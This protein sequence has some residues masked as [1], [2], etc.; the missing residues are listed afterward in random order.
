MIKG[1]LTQPYDDLGARGRFIDARSCVFVHFHVYLRSVISSSGHRPT[2]RSCPSQG[3]RGSI[4][5]LRNFIPVA[6]QVSIQRGL[7]RS[8]CNKSTGASRGLPVLVALR[9]RK[10][11]RLHRQ[12]PGL[13]WKQLFPASP[14]KRIVLLAIGW[15]C[16]CGDRPRSPACPGA[17]VRVGY[18]VLPAFEWPVPGSWSRALG[19]P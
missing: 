7:P 11:V 17:C 16:R 18:R 13:K 6:G 1:H 9:L 19:W 4:P 2:G 14:G 8:W 5:E 3:R 10:P 12:D 15:C